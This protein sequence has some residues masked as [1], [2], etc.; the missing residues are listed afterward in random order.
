MKKTIT[1][2]ILVSLVSVNLFA[3]S[4]KKILFIGNSYTYGNSLP[5]A[6]AN[7]CKDNH[8]TIN[9]DSYAQGGYYLGDHARDAVALEKIKRPNWDYII[10]QDQSLAYAHYN[11]INT[12]PYAVFLDSLRKAFSPCGQTVF[13]ITWGR[14]NGD[15]YWCSPP[16]C[17][18]DT[19]VSRT[20]YEMDSTIQLN[21][22]F[23]TDS[24]K[25]SASPVGAVWRY[26][27][28]NYPNI[29]LFQVDESH[30]TE[31]GTY[32]AACC[33][34]TAIFKKNPL[35]ITNNFTLNAT[36]AA[37]IRTAVK[38]VMFDSLANWRIGTHFKS[39]LAA[40]N[41]VTF[42]NQTHN[43]TGYEWSFGDGNT[44]TEENPVH[45]YAANGNYTVKLK[46]HYCTST[47]S[48]SKVVVANT[49][50]STGLQ[51]SLE[52]NNIQVYPNPVS[53]QL[54]VSTDKV[55]Y[56]QL[57]NAIGQMYT[58]PYSKAGA[59]TIV[60]LSA[61]PAGVYMLLLSQN[62]TVFT[63]KIVKQ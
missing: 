49:H 32:A 28:R 46:T 5:Q 43:A 34:Y 7:I 2:F 45:T 30:P 52:A 4:R 21:Y 62:T 3:Q 31:E 51:N 60:D 26:I 54:V 25:A 47:D 11:F 57:V 35:S 1:L 58:L 6:L 10:L 14:K 13:Y 19:L 24:I 44:S 41:V 53:S 29:E 16:Y 63:H 12:V 23:A 55:D 40:N 27:R 33:F 8:D 20:Y 18:T 37:N 22:M 15:Q 9:V 61:F 17:E 56:I 59:N 42:Q 48:T 38:K 39:T 50:V 36:D